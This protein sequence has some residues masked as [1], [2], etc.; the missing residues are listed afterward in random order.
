V[1]DDPD[2]IYDR[3]HS[4]AGESNPTSYK[5]QKVDELLERGRRTTD[6]E[7]RKEIYHRIHEI[8][9]DDCPAIFFASGYEFIG[10]NYRFR[11]SRFS[12]ML[13][14]LSTIKDWQIAGGEKEGMIYQ[15]R[16]RVSTMS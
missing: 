14:F 1:G 15:R 11:D 4:Q 5:N 6:F 16:Q 3:W 7:E 12:S 2:N 13:H 10:S 9:H 8:I